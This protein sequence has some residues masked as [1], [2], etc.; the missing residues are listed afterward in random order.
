MLLWRKGR[1]LFFEFARGVE[2]GVG[3]DCF[4]VCLSYVYSI[5]IVYLYY[6]ID[7]D[8]LGFFVGLVE[9]Y[10]VYLF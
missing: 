9:S 7:M 1:E 5:F 6:V 4:I 3:G 8:M 2:I 10:I